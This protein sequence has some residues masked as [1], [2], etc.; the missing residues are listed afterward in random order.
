MILLCGIRS[1]RPL[2][3]VAAELE[4]IG[5]QYRLFNQRRVSECHMSW[6]VETT[7]AVTGLLNLEGEV[8]PLEGITAAYVRLM[9][10]RVLPELEDQPAGSPARRHARG[11]HDALYRWLEIAPGH[12]VNR[13]EPQGSN[14]SKPYQ[15]QLIAG[16]G[17]LV[18]ETLIT[19]DP[20]AVLAFEREHGPLVYKSISAVRSIVQ[21]F[22][23][24]DRARL[25][26]IRWCP[27]QFQALIPGVDVRVHVVGREVFATEIIS[28]VLDYRYARKSGG[29]AELRRFE[30]PPNV[31]ERCVA[32]AAGL[33]LPFVGIDLKVTPTGEVYCFEVNPCPAFSYFEANTGQPIAHAVARY[34]IE[35]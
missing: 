14:G 23:E 22:G 24:E 35:E 21:R 31:A 27:V 3:M 9:D 17:F 7:G 25:E 16:F 18:P 34:L 1:E 33:E 26:L 11:F 10:D 30:L 19:N 15:A 5:R 2:A 8:L 13:A 29:K 6:E 28:D 4:G 20:E 12:I 32:A